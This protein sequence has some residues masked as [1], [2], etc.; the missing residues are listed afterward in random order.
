LSTGDDVG[1]LARP[2]V[3]NFRLE[4][5]YRDVEVEVRSVVLRMDFDPP[6]LMS[7]AADSE[8]LRA[9]QDVQVARAQEIGA[10]CGS[11][12]EFFV[13]YRAATELRLMVVALGSEQQSR[14]ERPAAGRGFHA[15]DN[16][17]DIRQPHSCVGRQAQRTRENSCF[18]PADMVP[19]PIAA[20]RKTLAGSANRNQR[21]QEA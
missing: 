19:R 21:E 15:S 9:G 4:L 10:M 17:R 14:L 20:A 2:H 13:D 3:G 7:G 18:L 12:D 8:R 1:H 11:E 6:H 5:N 16:E